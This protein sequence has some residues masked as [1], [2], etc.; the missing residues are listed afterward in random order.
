M[1]YYPL[2]IK[3]KL[4]IIT[5]LLLVGCSGI[6]PDGEMHNHR[7]EGPKKGLF[8]GE[9]GEFVIMAPDSSQETDATDP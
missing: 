7:E 8:S 6:T 2:F 4:V 3:A 1:S 5:A 9:K